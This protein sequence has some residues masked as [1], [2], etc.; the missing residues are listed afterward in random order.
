MGIVQ[1][2][3]EP[4]SAEAFAPFGQ[5]V[6][7]SAAPATSL[8]PDFELWRTAFGVDGEM[9]LLFSRYR[10]KPM[11]FCTMERHFNV[12]QTF[13]PLGPG[14]SVMVV[15]APTDAADPEAIPEPGA[16]HAFL[17]DNSLGVLLWKGTWHALD[18]FPAAPPHADF[19]L[20]TG[21]DTQRELER[22]AVEGTPTSLTQVV[23]FQKR[24]SIEFQVT[25]PGNLL[26][27][28]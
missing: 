10:H 28:T 9:E 26:G 22:K 16:V 1:V 25:D 12:T 5:V 2:A 13:L 6:G 27:A 8:S 23:D 17:L 15:A 19:A 4:L 11:R 20:L 7:P 3:V 21:R 24:S 14:A 18:R